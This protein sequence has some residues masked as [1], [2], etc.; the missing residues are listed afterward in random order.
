MN[1]IDMSQLCTAED[2]AAAALQAARDAAVLD[3]FEFA[4]AAA[5]ANFITFEEAAQWAAGNAMPAAVQAVLDTLSAAEKGPATLDV[6]ARPV[7][8]RTGNLM[9]AIAAAFETDDAGLDAL[10][11]IGGA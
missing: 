4:M 1:N 2:K 5:Q 9:P 10:F 11:G 6:L 7:I 3:R 8:R